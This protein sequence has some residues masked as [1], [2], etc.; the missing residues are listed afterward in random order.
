VTDLFEK[1]AQLVMK[2]EEDHQVQQWD[3]EGERISATI[4]DLKQRKNT[5][6]IMEHVKGA[7]DMKKLQVELIAAQTQKKECQAQMELLQER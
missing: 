4:E 2:L 3:Q 5:M 6:P 1:E 7:H